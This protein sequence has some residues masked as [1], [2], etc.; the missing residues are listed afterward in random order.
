MKELHLIFIVI[1]AFILTL[2]GLS[3]EVYSA[4]ATTLV[5]HYHRFDPNYSGWNLWLWPNKPTEGE[6]NAYNFNGE[7][8]FGKVLTLELADTNLVGATELG[9]IVRTSSWEKDVALDRFID[10]TNPNAAGEVHV[11]IVSGD[12]TIYYDADNVDISARASNVNFTSTTSV[13][14]E[15]SNAI[16]S[17]QLVLTENSSPLNILNFSQEGA[18]VTFD[19][20]NEIDLTNKYALTIDFEEVD[21]DPKTYT[22]G[23]S[24][25]Y[26]ST[27][28]N[29]AYGYDGELGAIY[30]ENE[31]TFRLWAPISESVSLNLY[32]K[33]HTADEI[34]Y[35]GTAGTDTPYEEYDLEY[36]EKGMWEV[37][38]NGDLH[39]IYYTFDVTNS[40]NTFEV[41]DPY[42]YSTGVN[43]LRSM[44]VDFNRLN[45]E[46][47]ETT[48]LPGEYDSYN[49]SI[50][51]ELH[52]R[53]FT[54]HE[55]WNGT[56]A[57]RGKFLGLTE[58]NTTYNGV[59]TGLDHIIELGVTHIQLLPVFDFGAAVDETRLKDE[60]Y[61]GKKDTIFNWGYM[62]ENFNS[63]E[64]SY[65]TDPYDG[66]VRINEYKTMI[67]TFHENGLRVIMDV[68]YNHHGRSAD[69][70]FD[71][72]VPG[73]YFRMTDDGG[74]SNGS[75]T[76]NETASERYMMRKFIVDSVVFWAQEY[77][78]SGFR[79]DLM[80]LHDKETMRQV[81]EKLH[82][83]DPS[84]MV[85][86]E[87]WTGGTS[88]LEENNSAYKQTLSE[89]PGVAVFNDNI[90]DAIKGSVF[91]E[92]GIGFVQGSSSVDGALQ[93]GILGNTKTWAPNPNQTINYTTAHD[94]NVLYDKLM[95]STE[96]LSY[97]AIKNMQKQ[98][99]A[100]ILTSNGI[101]FLHAGV[102]IMRTKPCTV[103]DG[104][105]QGECDDNLLYDH[106]S[107]RSPDQT[108][109]I[110]WSWKEENLDVFNYYKGLIELRKNIDVFSYNNKED[111]ENKYYFFPDN[112]GIISYII[113]DAESPWEYTYVIH[114]NSVVERQVNLQ[115]KTWNLVV[116]RDQAGLE[117]IAVL[118]GDT[119]TVRENETLVMYQLNSDMTWPDVEDDQDDTPIDDIPIQPETSNTI[120][121]IIGGIIAG[122]SL[123]TGAVLFFKKSL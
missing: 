42:A 84:I 98:A 2:S 35:T 13:T 10:M 58:T 45:P 107:Y 113:Y 69:S 22:I 101:P 64:G 80:K 87:P 32:D 6:G 76:G 70:N 103:I 59:T 75:G 61:T 43:G 48:G 86:G 17:D 62:P 28:F 111:F 36:I 9:M 50:I 79:F 11:Y 90:R 34:D 27:E 122:I 116:N 8:E 105:S 33:G 39:G 91:D 12:E 83:I 31:T 16:T 40:G 18:T 52:V 5:A 114:N 20:E 88:L 110:D 121:Y 93:N 23:F 7:D 108:N 26:D 71:L 104:E 55:T 56:D 53:D 119:V 67:Q 95:L 21:Q 65:S 109:Q 30:G 68:V 72:I 51:Y 106:N 38:I 49:E 29:N 89:M 41:S 82:Q 120:I 57:Y 60:N 37:S 118:D 4:E 115:N 100:I 1:L 44:V 24:G 102:D 78:I 47:W 15:S 46:N 97:D 19:L 99:N 3:T 73:Y 66:S 94:N 14:F 25:L 63:V 112:G 81:A 123:I 77:K 117:T 85:Y 54:T 96:D 92:E 74:F